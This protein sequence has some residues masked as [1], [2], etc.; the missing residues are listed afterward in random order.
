MSINIIETEWPRSGIMDELLHFDFGLLWFCFL[1]EQKKVLALDMSNNVV[2]E[3]ESIQRIATRDNTVY[4]NL[5]L[6]AFARS[7]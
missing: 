1:A 7:H 5:A 3:N 2:V 6:E 4:S